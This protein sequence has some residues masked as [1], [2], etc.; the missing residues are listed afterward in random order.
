MTYCT[1]FDFFSH[2]NIFK[3]VQKMSC[4][5][6]VFKESGIVNRFGLI[7]GHLTVHKPKIVPSPFN[8]EVGGGFD[9]PPLFQ[10][11]D[12]DL[13]L[14]FPYIPGLFSVRGGG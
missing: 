9:P 12:L 3:E 13:P 5:G 11:W 8:F 6:F 14:S 2:E 10:R 4:F 1:F 7:S